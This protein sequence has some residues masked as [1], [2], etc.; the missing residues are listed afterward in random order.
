MSA[1][2]AFWSCLAS[3]PRSSRAW[4]RTTEALI[5]AGIDVLAHPLR[6]LSWRGLP[7]PTQH[8][9]GVAR[10]LAETGV[11]SADDADRI[12]EGLSAIYRD[13][14]DGSFEFHIA[15][16]DIHMAIERVLTERIGTAGGRLHTARSRNDQV[17][18][19]G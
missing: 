1:P 9:D 2:I 10:M 15:D 19:T 17:A 6:Y 8:Y 4:I 14:R 18:A 11:I 16:E 5:G 12:E 3:L 13:I 7:R